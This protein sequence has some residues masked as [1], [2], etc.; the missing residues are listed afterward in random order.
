MW[1]D[2]SIQNRRQTFIDDL[3]TEL[4]NPSEKN[5][6]FTF[7]TLAI[8]QSPPQIPS[9]IR[10]ART[11][12]LI[13]PSPSEVYP[14]STIQQEEPRERLPSRVTPPRITPSTWLPASNSPTFG[15]SPPGDFFSTSMLG[16]RS[17]PSSWG[18]SSSWESTAQVGVNTVQMHPEMP[19]TQSSSP[20]TPRQDWAVT[21]SA[22]DVRGQPGIREGV[23][24][25][26]VGNVGNF[27]HIGNSRPGSSSYPYSR[28]T[29][30]GEH[31]SETTTAW[32]PAAGNQLADE[33]EEPNQLGLQNFK[34]SASFVTAATSTLILLATILGIIV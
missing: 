23:N 5:D 10:N 4:E 15:N 18:R 17:R 31:I 27:G 7:Q 9:S 24:I 21:M 19:A 11:P 34:N 25:G 6:N 30:S 29:S 8:A 2:S 28:P 1:I 26:N 16:S 33:V 14:W 22:W 13:S 12:L 3:S 32:Y 20:S